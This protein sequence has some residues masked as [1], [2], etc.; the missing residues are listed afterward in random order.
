MRHVSTLL[1]LAALALPGCSAAPGALPLATAAESHDSVVQ[2]SGL[3]GTKAIAVT[4]MAPHEAGFRTLATV[5]KWVENDIFEYRATLKAWDGLAYANFATPLTITIPRK[6]EGAKTKA[7]FTNLKQ[8]YKY[9][10]S[11]V[12][13]GNNGGGAATTALNTTPA[14]DVFD[15]TATQDVQ[16]TQ[17]ANLQI[18]FDSVAFNG[19]G[20]T[21]VAAP[22]DGTYANPGSPET[23]TAE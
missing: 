13:Y 17:S 4:V 20:E 8:G 23:G 2:N 11:L 22:E 7:V 10:V 16:D 3:S 19:S 1:I 18:T 9:Q 15:F 12:A 6:G 5:H 21:T 14:Q